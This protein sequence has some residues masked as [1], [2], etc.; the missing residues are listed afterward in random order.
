MKLTEFKFDEQH[1]KNEIVRDNKFIQKINHSLE[2]LVKHLPVNKLKKDGSF[3]FNKLKMVEGKNYDWY[4]LNNKKT[5]ILVRQYQTHFTFFTKFTDK[6]NYRPTLSI[7]TIFDNQEKMDDDTSDS[8][9]DNEFQSITK[10]LPQLVSIIEDDNVHSLWNSY[11]FKVENYTEVKIGMSSRESIPSMD[12]LI[13]GCDELF[14]K[15]VSTYAEND[16]LEQIKK[17][18]VGDK[19]GSSYVI[20]RVDTEL[21]DD[22]YHSCGLEFS[23]DNFPKSEPKWTDV[24]SLA[25]FYSEDL[26][27]ENIKIKN[28]IMKFVHK[29][30]NKVI[31]E[32]VDKQQ[33]EFFW[34]T[35]VDKYIERMI[36]LHTG[37]VD[38]KLFYKSID[39]EFRTF[40]KTSYS[41]TQ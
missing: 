28:R 19:F 32:F 3:N 16:V 41:I 36:E 31:K 15:Y 12:T 20:T 1:L 5:T 33:Q 39:K 18:K 17:F 26:D 35:I 14:G 29:N 30:H 10:Y 8:F 9:C 23:N 11:S 6:W 22:Y 4:F 34:L 40:I 13:F 37:N 25:T 27:Y 21:E 38:S 7:F 2:Y 24:Y